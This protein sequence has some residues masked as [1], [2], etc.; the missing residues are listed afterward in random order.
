MFSSGRMM[1][2]MLSSRLPGSKSTAVPTTRTFLRSV[3]LARGLGAEGFGG[4]GQD[5]RAALVHQRIH[6]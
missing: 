5:G 6:D 1:P 4:L 3:V 2:N